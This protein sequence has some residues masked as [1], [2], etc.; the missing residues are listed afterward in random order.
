MNITPD[1]TN[2]PASKMSTQKK[3]L[4]GCGIGCAAIIGLFFIIIGFGGWWLFS[5]EDQV[6]T[7]RI[8]N[9]ASSGAFRLEDLSEN[10]EVLQLVSDVSRAA[11][12][13]NRKQ[14]PKLP[15]YL[16][17]LKNYFEG[18]EDPARFIELIAP[19]EAT[20]SLSSDEAGNIDFIVAANFGKGTRIVKLFLNSLFESNDELK[21]KK[22]STGH[23]DLFLFEGDGDWNSERT[24]Q[25]AVGFYEGTFILGNDPES[26]I[27]ALDRLSE[28]GSSGELNETL[29][30]S[31]YR[32][33]SE[34]ALAYGVFDGSQLKVLNHGTGTFSEELGSGMKKAEISLDK[35]SGEKGIVNLHM[36]WNSIEFAAKANEEI[37][38]LKTEWVRK[39]EQEGFNMEIINSLNDEQL[40]IQFRVND[41]KD[42]LIYLIKNMD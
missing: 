31:F 18:Q 38:K 7:D 15:E 1:Y 27:S 34:G 20:L 5:Q 6:P 32:A 24:E 10:Q 22:I 41:L 17:G 28:E 14:V 26:A 29:S 36:D 39:A 9:T 40:D 2:R 21:N 13:N 19:K 3:T 42:S 8:L 25:I 16:E 11:R 4:I 37:E 30:E 12:N 35:L 23:G 33:G